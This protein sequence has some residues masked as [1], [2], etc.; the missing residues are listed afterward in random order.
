MDDIDQKR[1]DSIEE[2]TISLR[3][4]AKDLIND[5]RECSFEC[6]RMLLGGLIKAMNNGYYLSFSKPIAPFRGFSFAETQKYFRTIQV[7]TCRNRKCY[8][9]SSNL[10]S[11]SF[12]IPSVMDSLKHRTDGLLPQEYLPVSEGMSGAHRKFVEQI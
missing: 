10:C 11:L 6:R 7:P 1:E 5:K 9:E 2:M 8:S 3:E 4:L 12:C